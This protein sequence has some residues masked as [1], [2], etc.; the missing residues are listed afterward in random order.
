MMLAGFITINL[1]ALA[2]REPSGLS[3]LQ[4]DG[5]SI[6]TRRFLCLDKYTIIRRGERILLLFNQWKGLWSQEGY[7]S[8]ALHDPTRFIRRPAASL[9]LAGNFIGTG[10]GF[11]DAPRNRIPSERSHQDAAT[12]SAETIPPAALVKA[13]SIPRDRG[14]TAQISHALIGD[15]SGE[16]APDVGVHFQVGGEAADPAGILVA[17]PN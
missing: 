16:L 10:T 9:S 4:A 11:W 1:A 8:R 3:W 17:E 12:S 13:T 15:P 6:S 7:N 14:R 5:N 2:L